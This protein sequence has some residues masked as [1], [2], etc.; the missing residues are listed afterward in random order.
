MKLKKL[1]L[2]NWCQHSN[3]SIVFPDDALVRLGGTNNC[4]KTNLIRAIGRVLAQG[5]SDFGDIN[6]VQ[7]GQDHASIV[8]DALNSERVPFTLSRIIKDKTEVSLIIDGQEPIIRSESIQLQ[9]TEWFG[10]QD[11]LLSLFIAQQGE[12]ASLLKAKGRDRL[13]QFIE[14]CGFKGFLKR[15]EA[16][17]KFIKVYPSI[18]D[19]G[20][21]LA[22]LAS[23]VQAAK[24]SVAT[25]NAEVSK[26]EKLNILRLRINKLRAE[27]LVLEQQVADLDRK[28]K[29]LGVTAVDTTP[30]PD[31][32]SIQASITAQEFELRRLQDGITQQ[33]AADARKELSQVKQALGRILLDATDYSKAIQE[34]SVALQADI[35]QKAAIEK[36]ES[37][38]TAAQD[39]L[40]ELIDVITLSDKLLAS[41]PYSV[42]WMER[43]IAELKQIMI[44]LSKREAASA[45]QNK[46][47]EQLVALALVP[48]PTEGELALL[49]SAENSKIE[50]IDLKKHAQNAITTGHEDCPLCQQPWLKSAIAARIKEL[51]QGING[52][53]LAQEQSAKAKSTYT[54]WIEAQASQSKIREQLQVETVTVNTVTSDIQ[55]LLT[56]WKLKESELVHIHDIFANYTRVRDA[57]TAPREQLVKDR[58]AVKSLEQEVAGLTSIKPHLELRISG[59]TKQVSDL[60]S[61]QATAQVQVNEQVR[62]QQQIK[63][64]EAN[65][66]KL[67]ANIKDIPNFDTSIDYKQE[68]TKAE[69]KLAALRNELRQGG[70]RYTQAQKISQLQSEVRNLLQKI[71]ENPWTNEQDQQLAQLEQQVNVQQQTEA[72]LRLLEEQ[73]SALNIEIHTN[74]EQLALFKIQSKN[75]AD[76]QAVSSFLSY[77]NGPQKFLQVFFQDT[78]NQTNLLLSEMGLPVSLHMGEDLEIMVTDSKKRVSSSLALGGGFSNLIGIAFRIAL[79]K[80]IL[81]RVN[82]VILDEPSTHIDEGNMELLVPFFEHLKD[83]LHTYGIEQCLLIDHH[84]A[85]RNSAVP[86]I[87]IGAE[88]Q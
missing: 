22:D 70:E 33:A 74:Q 24:L 48:A 40:K 77:D 75:L 10:R 65:I 2:E 14:I 4:G 30:L 25:K 52:I 36:K 28:K 78:L 20:P 34:I 59:A 53:E 68:A 64:A 76:M 61:K 32:A 49:N 43:P 83:N 66:H 67:Y 38:L 29:E 16:L 6:D 26:L 50:L 27:K 5:R 12:I 23:R 9:L 63:T 55:K 47:K 80:M 69:S 62:L 85:W 88:N 21:I 54:K 31:L 13:V 18:Q 19:P 3:L 56:T 84:P 1:Q 45:N 15:Q 86:V 8:L 41:L 71:S 51:E 87:Q 44:L 7:Y 46:F 17:N 35:A 82:T 11:T 58:L 57:I 37:G 73:I 39:K 79:Q 72:E 42:N 60:L 81:P